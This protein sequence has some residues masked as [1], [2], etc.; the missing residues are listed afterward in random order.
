M[1]DILSLIGTSGNGTSTSPAVRVNVGN[2]G[3]TTAM[4]FLNNGSVGIGTSTPGANLEIS[5]H[6]SSPPELRLSTFGSGVFGAPFI[7]FYSDRG[8]TNEWRP[9]YII[10]G[11]NGN[12]T[13]RLDFY[14]DGTG[15]GARGGSTLG[16]SV[17]NGKVGIGMST[18]QAK[19][20]L[21]SDL[22]AQKLLIFD[23]ANVRYGLGMASAEFRT[24]A[25][26]GASF[27][28]GHISNSDGST[29]TERVRIDSNGNLGIGTPSPS[30]RLHT[31]STT[32]QLRVGY[33]ASNYY[34]TTVSSV[35]GVTLDAV[36][37]GAKFVFS[38]PVQ[39]S[40]VGS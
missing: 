29:Y 20:S 38:D 32:E 12:Y 23:T 40:S 11:D 26:A 10:S 4:T 27:T 8:T 17:V 35:G 3:A 5:A 37:S 14:T 30:A 9:G 15:S 7:S 21:G 25:A 36:G 6:Y 1:T 31:I 2:N 22:T 33:D 39:F 28:F 19:L 24:F 16:L 13:G 18:P 34:K